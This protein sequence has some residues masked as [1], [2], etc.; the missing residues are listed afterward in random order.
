MD[1]HTNSVSFNEGK[2]AAGGKTVP[3]IWWDSA[4][5]GCCGDGGRIDNPKEA[6]AMLHELAQEHEEA[7][8]AI[9]NWLGRINI[10]NQVVA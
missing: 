2:N 10:A 3:Y 8:E 6:K 7:A 9:R 4:G 5:C 1:Y